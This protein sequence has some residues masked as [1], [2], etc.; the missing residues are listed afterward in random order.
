[1]KLTEVTTSLELDKRRKK[2]N[3]SYPLKLM[4]IFNRQF[5]RYKTKYSFTE[6]EYKEIFIEKKRK[7][8]DIRL[9]VEA[10]ETKA[11]DIIEELTDF[12]FEMFGKKFSKKKTGYNDIYS[13]FDEYIEILRKDE[14]INTATTYEYAKKSIQ[15]FTAKKILHHYDITPGFL[16]RYENWM[17][18]N[19]RSKTTV[20]IYLRNLKAIY[21]LNIRDKAIGAESK[22]FG[23]GK[24]EIPN[25]ANI[26]KSMSISDIKKIYDYQPEE[27]S[28][29]H[30]FRDLWLLIYFCNGI[31][32][33]DICL[34]R[35]RDVSDTSIT[36]IRAKTA[37]S[38]SDIRPI[39]V[40]LIPEAKTIL[41][42]WRNSSSN[43]SSGSSDPDGFVFPF[44]KHPEDPEKVVKEVALVVAQ[45]N[46]YIKRVAKKLGIDKNPTSYYARHSFATILMRNNVSHSYI[47]EALG[48]SSI[49]T[50]ES[51]LGSFEDEQ[52]L[53]VARNL[54]RWDK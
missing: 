17:L 37:R 39:V 25:P 38:Q 13:S 34:L 22:P 29:E 43:G 3:N 6:E 18:R 24:Y 15:N 21:N 20:G 27:G 44:I 14:K 5:Q 2:K 19:K 16:K 28:Q 45:V 30:R 4:V 7:H 23:K 46:K 48:H 50:T 42:R 52:K 47:K 11:Q 10:L 1:M 33:K 36:F 54:T 12:T 32:I 40:P 41:E 9:E 49:R 26:K 31:N 35:N 8:K 51:Y 53:E